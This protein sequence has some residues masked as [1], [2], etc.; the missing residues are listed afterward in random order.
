[1]TFK[2]EHSQVTVK[3][4]TTDSL[5]QY[6]CGAVPEAHLYFVIYR[7][8]YN[9]VRYRFVQYF[10]ISLFRGSWSILWKAGKFSDLRFANKQ[11]QGGAV[12]GIGVTR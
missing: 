1:M 2:T 8:T 10:P 3:G 7:A 9:D 6:G 5:P 4:V 11:V 12:K